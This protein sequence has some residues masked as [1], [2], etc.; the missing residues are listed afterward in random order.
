MN[1]K[2][3][4]VIGNGMAGARLV[5]D[6]Y[7]R[8]GGDRFDVVMFGDEPC[9]NYNRI[10]LSS[11]LSRSHKPDDIFINPMS[12]YAAKGVT[13]HAGIRVEQIDLRARQVT[14]AGGV[15]ERYDTLVIATGSTPMIPPL[16]NA[17]DEDG[18]FKHGVFVFR[19]LDDCERIMQCAE[20][21]RRAAVIGGGLLGLEAA[22][23]L[24]NWGLETHVIHLMPHLMEAQLDPGAAG[25]LRRQ[26]DQM[27]LVTHLAT[28]TTAVVGN[29]HVQGLE[30]ADG[31]TLECDLVVI[32]AGIRPN[33]KLAV[34]AGLKVNRGIVVGDD[35]GCFAEDNR[36]P[37][38][39]AV[40]ECAE[41]RGRVYGLVAPL[42]EQTARLAD[43][44]SGR[45]PDAVYVGSTVSTKL[46]VMGV[47]LAVMG[48]KEPVG[49]DDEVV[50]Y[51]EPSRGIYKKLIVRNDRLVGAIIL[52][53]GAVVPSLLQTFTSGLPITE[54]R[55]DV[56]FIAAPSAMAGRTDA[57]A[58]PDAARICD[59]NGVSKAQIIEAVLSGARSVQAVCD[60]TRASTG[61]GSCRP[62]VEAIVTLACQGIE[63]AFV[64]ETTV[65]QSVTPASA[66]PSPEITLNK[67]E[68]FKREKDGL[69][70]EADI[71]RFASD[72]WETIGESDRERLKWLGVFFR[73]QT[74][75]RFM[76]RIRMPN[77]FTNAEQLA[78]IADLSRKC[79]TGFVDIT[80]RQQI[81]L[82]GFGVNDLAHI[83]DRLNAV[84]LVS[85]QTGMDNIRNVIGCPVAGLTDD[86]LF[87]ASPIVRQFSDAFL[88]NKA[89]TNL[90]RKFNVAITGCTENCTHGETQ[91]LSLTPA[92]KIIDGEEVQGFNFA[93]G[94][95]IGSGGLRPATPLGVFCRPEDAVG[96][97]S[98]ITLI[99]RD[100]GPRKA[101]NRARLAFLIEEWGVERFK[102]ELERR[103]GGR[104]LPQGRDARTTRHHDHLGIS[105][106]KQSGLCAVGLSVPVGRISADQLS[107]LARVA[108]RYGTGEVRITTSQ[109]VIVPNV[110]ESMLPEM[111][112]E[113]LL[114]EL[115][116]DPSDMMRG[117]VSCT[118]I[119]YCHMALIETKELAL[120]TA[121]E[122]D[123]RLGK[124]K[125]LLTMHWSGCPAGCGNHTAA[126]IGLLG[127]NVKIG[128]EIVDAV[129]VFVGGQSGPNAKAGMKILED[130]PCSDLP[131]VLEQVIPYV[132]NKRAARGAK[133]D[134]FVSAAARA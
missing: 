2:R 29:G 44:L 120:K 98:H 71:E 40:G 18:V 34:D 27:G 63:Q 26:F 109:N 103:V 85:L 9:G 70:V 94:G 124:G 5:D 31:A 73:R 97:C 55:A 116:H 134:V 10:L 91:D 8:G 59:C 96:L 122:L 90:P 75:G 92:I 58:A 123:A 99:F 79:G 3:L 93:V 102:C 78:V 54:N 77:G 69:D 4:V 36:A 118:G 108:G 81:Q 50:S 130:V 47:D 64:P 17:R 106:Q 48:D 23:G 33:T 42:W 119:D 126:D 101:R 67:I 131:R 95:K 45:N 56:L 25:V 115:R 66:V 129:D 24:L 84:Q 61:C 60:V 113:P 49:D 117:V 104:L 16:A 57:A 32:A 22:R 80:T 14:G 127:K 13:L 87:D 11:V 7:S 37:D 107:G 88:R 121:R 112:S 72:G 86:E 38:V 128:D 133:K 62:E 28:R 82:R 20:T 43:R 30:F 74:P 125:K 6:L 53:D 12:W 19:T 83:W 132:T 41:H 15:C 100:F 114:Q 89:F 46:K 1:K 111:T 21:A 52:G 65:A 51:S 68:R 76:M 105:R 35:L 39:F 110:P